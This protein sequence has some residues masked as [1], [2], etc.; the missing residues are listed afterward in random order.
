MVPTLMFLSGVNVSVKLS[1][2]ASKHISE[3]TES[4]CSNIRYRNATKPSNSAWLM[5]LKPVSDLRCL[6]DVTDCPHGG[7]H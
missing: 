6:Q 5:P 3:V 2:E 7:Q 1:L 4:H